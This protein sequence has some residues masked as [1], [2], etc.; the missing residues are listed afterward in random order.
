MKGKCATTLWEIAKTNL[1]PRY[2][3]VCATVQ[4]LTLF[5]TFTTAEINTHNVE[6]QTII[7]DRKLVPKHFKRDDVEYLYQELGTGG[8]L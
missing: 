2:N 5:L 6:N 4:D 8:L 1:V 7:N 3:G